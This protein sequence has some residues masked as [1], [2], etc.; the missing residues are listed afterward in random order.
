MTDNLVRLGMALGVIA[1]I[2]ACLYHFG[3]RSAGAF[4]PIGGY[5]R[6]K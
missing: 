3:P 4:E 2:T 6:V 1:L 5:A